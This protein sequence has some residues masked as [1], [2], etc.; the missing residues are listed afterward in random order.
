VKKFTPTI[1]VVTSLAFSG[2]LYA[3]Y[4][5]YGSGTNSCGSWV[6]WRKTKSGWHQD[7][8]WVNGFVSAAGY[9]GKELKEVDSDAMLVFMDNYCQQNPLNKIGDGAKALV[10]ELESK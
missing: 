2:P 1:L 9:F 5:E 3:V 6:K 4:T 8:Q 7:G 10:R